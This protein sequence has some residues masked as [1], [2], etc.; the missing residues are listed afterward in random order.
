MP[1][2]WRRR[3]PSRSRR[4]LA[5]AGPDR[6][7]VSDTS[8]LTVCRLAAYH[9]AKRETATI[10]KTLAT[11]EELLLDEANYEFVLAFL[12]DL[13]NLVSHGL[14]T[15]ATPEQVTARG[16][17]SLVCWRTLTEFRWI[18]ASSQRTQ[19]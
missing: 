12:E 6:R 11:A 2:P 1:A 17:N 4:L 19:T 13:Q 7:A 14:N 5:A 18:G 16:P 9:A 15:F 10:E 3:T 8:D